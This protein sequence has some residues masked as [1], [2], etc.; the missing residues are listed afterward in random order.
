MFFNKAKL[1]AVEKKTKVFFSCR[2]TCKSISI[3][4]YQTFSIYK[5]HS[6]LLIELNAKPRTDRAGANHFSALGK[7]HFQRPHIALEVILLNQPWHDLFK[8][9]ETHYLC[10]L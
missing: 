3:K 6:K 8:R 5:T 10:S 1:R 7:M 4:I 9:K 2:N